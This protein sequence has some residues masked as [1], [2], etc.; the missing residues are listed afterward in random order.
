MFVLNAENRNLKLKPKHLRKEG[1]IPGVLYGKNLEESLSLQFSQAEVKRFLQGNFVGSKAELTVEGKKFPALLREVSYEP[2]ASNLQHL[3]FQ[4][5]IA[6]EAITST[7]AIVLVNK[8]KVDGMVQH[9][10]AE[11][12]YRTLPANLVD[13]FEIDLEGMQI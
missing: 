6:G 4:T 7:A 12:S 10:L 3:S 13:R 11:I 1:I 5:L 8:E 9:Q 2:A